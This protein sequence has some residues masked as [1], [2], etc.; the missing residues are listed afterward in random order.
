MTGIN[1]DDLHSYLYVSEDYGKN[2]KSINKGLPDEPVNVILED[3]TNEN[4]LYA[5]GLRGVFISIDR[6]ESWSCLGQQIPDVAIAD[7]EVQQQ[8]MELVAATHGRG[9]YKIELLPIQ[10]IA[11]LNLPV[12]QDHLFEVRDAKRPKYNS[13]GGH[14]DYSTAEK[15]SFTFWLK[16]AEKIKLAVVDTAGKEVWTNDLPGKAGFNQYNW[17]MIVS[18]EKSDLPYFVHYEKFIKAGSYTLLV[19]QGEMKMEKKF[20]VANQ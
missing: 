1:Y 5:G 11:T 13:W 8:T 2:W 12:N 15:I 10:R 3:P 9:I 4:I 6:G 20:K 19:T 14:P 18:R 7:L 16:N 17:D